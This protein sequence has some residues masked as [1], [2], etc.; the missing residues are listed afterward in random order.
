LTPPRTPTHSARTHSRTARSWGQPLRA[1]MRTA[2]APGPAVRSPPRRAGH[3][4]GRCTTTRATARDV[5]NKTPA[6]DS[7]IRTSPETAAPRP[8][9]RSA[10]QRPQGPQRSRHSQALPSPNCECQDHERQHCHQNDDQ[11]SHFRPLIPV[12]TL[13]IRHPCPEAAKPPSRVSYAEWSH[14][15]GI[16]THEPASVM[17]TRPHVVR[18]DRRAKSV[19][20]KTLQWRGAYVVAGALRAF[21]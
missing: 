12:N 1:G 17:F 20:L 8:G 4:N 7:D 10:T 11:V 21:R 6:S 3:P 14:S 16:S 15:H 2:L 13:A 5:T 18:K 19:E 9:K